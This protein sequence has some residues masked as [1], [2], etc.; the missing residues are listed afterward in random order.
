MTE[1]W[2]PTLQVTSLT[3]QQEIERILNRGGYF[4]K[5][6]EK[7]GENGTSKFLGMTLDR[8]KDLY[9]LKFRLNLHKKSCGIPS[10]ADLDSDFLQDHS[11]PVTKKNIL[12]V[13]CQ[14][15]DPTGLAAPLMLSVRAL[16]SE[17]CRDPQ[18]SINS[19][20]S[21]ERTA[22]FRDVVREILQT[23]EIFFPRQVIFRYQ[24]QLFIFFDG[25]LQGYGACV[26]AHSGDQIN[27][28][29]SSSKILGKSAFSALQSEM[30][31]ALLAY[32]MEQKIK[33]KIVLRMIAKNDS[34]GNPVFYGVRLMEI[35]A[36]SSPNNWFW[37]P[38]NLNP[39]DLLTRSGTS[40]ALGQLRV[41]VEW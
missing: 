1:V 12:S 18:C 9:S 13:A 35:L 28:I 14:F 17:I 24:A 32:R 5:S 19:I 31:G 20:L 40:C 21:E 6:W 27:L 7:S 25:A 26:Y 10:G 8:L 30:A 34:A 11:I 39:A 16:F 2:E 38:G 37:C 23:R 22:K 33:P 29:S 15:Y 41:L 36:A 3:L 4:I